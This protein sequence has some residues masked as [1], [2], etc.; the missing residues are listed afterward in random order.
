VDVRTRVVNRHPYLHQLL[1]LDPR[2]QHHQWRRTTYSP[3][4]V[5]NSVPGT[6]VDST[7]GV[8]T[9]NAQQENQR[10]GL[11]LAGGML[12]VAYGSFADTDP[13]HGWV[14]GFNATN[15]Q[16]SAKLCFQYHAQRHRRHL[17]RQRRRRRAVDG[18]K[19]IV[20]GRQHQSLSLKRPT[21]VLAPTP[22]A[23]IMG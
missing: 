21:A 4:I 17:W 11:T 6:G 9:F 1:S 3:V 20:R 5:T 15:L 22:M 23:G 2:P 8:V 19:R 7:N 13:Y 18:R 10:P 14:I 16:S 12:Y